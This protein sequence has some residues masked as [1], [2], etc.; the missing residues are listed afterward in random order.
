MDI[1]HAQFGNVVV[2]SAAGRIDHAT[3]DEFRKR[4]ESLVEKVAGAGS[5]LV[6]D[7]SDVEYISSAGL[8]CF[9]LAA[10]QAKAH[11]CTMVVAALQ[12]V[13]KEIFDISRFTLVFET[14]QTVREAIQRLSPGALAAFDAGK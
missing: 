9:M 10:K 5:P 12:P 4:L 1:R 6:F 11:S 8:R 13:V 3:S 7:L 14:F 2:L